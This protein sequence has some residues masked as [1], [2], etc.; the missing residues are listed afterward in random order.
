MKL[1]MKHSSALFMGMLFAG[2]LLFTSC[3]KDSATTNNNG[4]NN[5]SPFWKGYVNTQ[6]WEHGCILRADGTARYYISFTGGSMSDTANSNV[7]KLEGTYHIVAANDSIYISC[8]SAGNIT[9][10]NLRGTLNAAQTTMSGTWV[11][12]GGGITNTL[13]FSMSK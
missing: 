3:K 1:T 2:I 13:P 10:Y 5:T 11:N 6:V 4:N 9:T 8:A 7:S 12:S